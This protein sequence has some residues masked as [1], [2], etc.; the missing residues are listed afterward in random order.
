[1]EEL[2]KVTGLTKSYK[3]SPAVSNLSFSVKK[4]E[5]LGLLGPNGAEKVQ[6][7]IFLRLY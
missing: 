6:Q 1:M 5:I 2:I 4:G 7:L 3:N